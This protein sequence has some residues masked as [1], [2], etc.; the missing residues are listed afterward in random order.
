MFKP[1]QAAR[2][3]LL[4]A[5]LAIGESRISASGD[6]SVLIAALRAL[7]ATAR[8]DRDGTWVIAGR[9]IGA[10]TEP[11]A[12]IA[13]G[14]DRWLLA[15]LAGLLGSHPIFAVLTGD[16]ECPDGLPQLLQSIGA[17]V[18]H[19]ASGGMPLA[20]AGARD[21]L[22]IDQSGIDGDLAI[23]ALV[24][25]LNARG[26]T[27]LAFAGVELPAE[28]ALGIATLRG[29][30]AEVTDDVED[31]QRVIRLRGQ[32][33]L[34]G[35]MIGGLVIAVDGPAAAGKGTLA[36]R[37]AAEF[38]LPYLDTGLLYRAV[39]RL[40]FD[41]GGDPADA[42]AAAEAARRLRPEDTARGDL[43]GPPV[44]GAASQ[45]GA[46]PAVRAALVD[47][48]RQFAGGQGGV[49]DGRDIG[50]VIFPDAPIKFFVTASADARSRR[51]WLELQ[52]RGVV[53]D[54]DQ[55][56]TEMRSRDA[57]DAA[58]AAAPMQ[59]AAD[60]VVLDTTDLDADAAFRVAADMVRRHIAGR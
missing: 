37:L 54:F 47:F 34:R 6:H 23:A 4:F 46:Y 33:E 32:P 41:A 3:A 18:Q 19:P 10:L 39:A 56:A 25:G 15:A 52:A 22:P 11:D 50:T 48:Q 5:G 53:A 12:V 1:D 16:A 60:A 31:G 13:V 58:R 49:L 45:V 21:A 55:I 29:F 27:S 28:I 8:Q 43:R 57:N 38:G 26:V 30:G 24:A 51:R 36:R 14:A 9:G 2:W 20:I 44:D 40:V 59:A 7:G 35:C 17:L 42:D